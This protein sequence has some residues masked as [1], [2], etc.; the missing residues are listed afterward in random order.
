MWSI[1]SITIV[2]LVYFLVGT[3]LCLGAMYLGVKIMDTLCNVDTEDQLNQGN[4]AVAIYYAGMFLG[5][6]IFMGMVGSSA[7]S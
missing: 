4:T 1:V 2:N 5:L 7:I 6:G 3:G